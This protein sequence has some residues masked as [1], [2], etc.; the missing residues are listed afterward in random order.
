MIAH[1][2]GRVLTHGGHSLI[3]AVGGVGYLVHT[4]NSILSSYLPGSEV[5]LFTHLVVRE[6]ALDLFGFET[7]DEVRFFELLIGVSGVGPRSALAI[8]DLADIETLQSVIANSDT[9]YLT[10]VS[11]I[12]KKSAEKI[13]VELRDKLEGF[14]T[15]GTQ[16]HAGDTDVIDALT[17]LGYSLPEAREALAYIPADLTTTNDRLTA[18]LK[19]LSTI[20]S[21]K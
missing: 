20:S 11:G 10:K 4:T 12:G 9:S 19:S 18:A 7:Q 14:A 13:V 21:H 1:L 17:A 15:T 2:S 3:L 16:A 8:M 6:Q 5:A